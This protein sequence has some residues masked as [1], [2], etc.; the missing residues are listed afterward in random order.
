MRQFNSDEEEEKAD[1]LDPFWMFFTDDFSDEETSRMRKDGRMAKTQ[2][3]NDKGSG[4][5]DYLIPEED[6]LGTSEQRD[7]SEYK[8]KQDRNGQSKQHHWRRFGRK[9]NSKRNTAISKDNIDLKQSIVSEQR[10]LPADHFAPTKRETSATKRG[11]S[12]VESGL[13]PAKGFPTLMEALSTPWDPWGE[14][15]SSESSAGSF[16]SDDTSRDDESTATASN[17]SLSLGTIDPQEV[18]Q[19][20]VQFTPLSLSS[21]KTQENPNEAGQPVL[22]PLPGTCGVALELPEI[23]TSKASH[24][25]AD[26]ALVWKETM[27][28]FDNLS[29]RLKMN[30]EIEGARQSSKWCNLQ[31]A[32]CFSQRNRTISLR[33]SFPID[34]LGKHELTT[35]FPKLRMVA[36]E[37]TGGNKYSSVVA[38][39]KEF[40]GNIPAHLQLSSEA[41]LATRGPQSLYEYEYDKGEHMDVAY[42][43]FGPNPISLLVTRHH[44]TPPKT[45]EGLIIQIE[46]S[47]ASLLLLFSLPALD[48]HT[49]HV[50]THSAGI[51]DINDGLQYAKR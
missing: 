13:F 23:E 44:I 22:A 46:A 21:G 19:I 4:F 39:S 10:D 48:S 51:D 3:V 30:E 7:P 5:F 12:D 27:D 29:P 36:D 14:Q 2:Q 45:S 25:R 50:L 47:V 49:Q 16:L 8:G 1:F 24:H 31:K 6:F 17:A 18:Q 20:L 11:A 15:S 28:N 9:N 40:R 38:N 32:A 34:E 37:K 26:S 33:R 41:Y 35:V 43:H 42:H